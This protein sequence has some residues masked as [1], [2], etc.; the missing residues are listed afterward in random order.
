M[1]LG[2]PKFDR[3]KVLEAVKKFPD[4]REAA[5][6]YAGCTGPTITRH[7]QRMAFEKGEKY[8]DRRSTRK[9]KLSG[10]IR[11]FWTDDVVSKLIGILNRRPKPLNCDIA[12]EMGCTLSALQT[13]SCRLPP[14]GRIRSI[15]V[16][17]QFILHYARD[18]TGCGKS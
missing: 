17:S 9:S 3:A 10:Q 8:R 2:R 12:I 11:V 14:R 15:S 13:S 4:S 5:A 7:L 1:K 16:Q 18:I 6:R